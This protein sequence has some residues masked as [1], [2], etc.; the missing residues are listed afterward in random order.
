MMSSYS[1]S[2]GVIGMWWLL[3]LVV[4]AVALGVAAWYRREHG[5]PREAT[6]VL[7][8]RYAEGQIDRQTYL[9]MLEELR[10]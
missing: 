3:L 2:M 1:W 4:L 10:R 9:R 8:Q 6:R 7:K 5:S